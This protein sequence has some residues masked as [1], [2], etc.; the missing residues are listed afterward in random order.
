MEVIA[1]LFLVG[2]LVYVIFVSGRKVEGTWWVLTGNVLFC[3]GSGVNFVRIS[4]E[5]FVDAGGNLKCSLLHR[6]V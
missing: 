6:A 1:C 2:I 3:V 5:G 4:R